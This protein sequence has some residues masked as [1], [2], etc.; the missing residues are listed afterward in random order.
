MPGLT[1]TQCAEGKLTG[2]ERLHS[3]AKQNRSLQFNNLLHHITPLMLTQAYKHLNR[4]SSR[5]VD[6]VSWKDFGT[7]LAK[8]IENLHQRLH[9]QKYKPQPVRRI[10]LP[11]PNGDKR[12]IGITAV[13]DKVVQQALVWLLEKIY[14][15][16]FLGFSYG[17]RP[18]RNQHKAL[19]AVYVAISQKKVSWILDADISRFFD[20]I[21]HEWLMTFLQHRIAD[22]RILHLIERT[23]KA[24][25]VDEEGFSKTVVGTPQGAVISPLLANIYLHY[26]LDLWA[27]Q[28]R[29]KYARGDCYIVRY[30][31][32]S[33]M[34]FQYKSDGECFERA[35]EG[36][37]EKFGLG[38]NR[39]KTK[40]LE[41]GRFALA[42]RKQKGQG[43]P[44]TFEFLGFTHFCS[45]K[46]SN[47]QF[48]IKRISSAKK[49]TAK[50]NQIRQHLY[51]IRSKD[52]Y[53][54]GRW[55]K[56]V[57]QGYNNYFAVPGNMKALSA[58]RS[59]ICRSWLKALRRRGQ[60]H[61]IS[62]KKLSKLIKL[63]IPTAK[64]LHPYPN[65]RLRV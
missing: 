65:M 1:A 34:G 41:F 60:R 49:M 32:D 20:T 43:K 6:N 46:R 12:P 13:E 52:I 2:L 7:D 5:G 45:I 27:N 59:E 25:V 9:A 55:L 19:D 57:V 21:N 17:F 15:V 8:K 54:Q 16:D 62:W 14:E 33:V 3:K 36:R 56:S 30:A 37:L 51:K 48:L 24:G 23:I 28:W 26:V 39:S 44:E 58:Y 61:P 63:F 47:G 22:R 35:L 64:I 10:W 53:A 11:K 18:T 4:K 29:Q 42:N 38:L 31:D 40:L 50:L